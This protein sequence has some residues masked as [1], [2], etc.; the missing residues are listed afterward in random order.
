MP[1][2]HLVGPAQSGTV[3]KILRLSLMSLRLTRIAV[4]GLIIGAIFVQFASWPWV[5]WF[6]SFVA[7]PISLICIFL[8][9]GEKP[10]RDGPVAPKHARWQGLD[11][12]G[13]SILTSENISLLSS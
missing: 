11:I 6:V 9:P 7:V 5:F 4:L 12:G 8:I 3:S 10:H 13:V 2:V 1:L